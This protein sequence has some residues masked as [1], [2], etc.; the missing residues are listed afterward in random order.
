MLFSVESKARIMAVDRLR[1][2]GDGFSYCFF[3]KSKWSKRYVVESKRYAA[4]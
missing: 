1:L 2:R 3:A 4:D